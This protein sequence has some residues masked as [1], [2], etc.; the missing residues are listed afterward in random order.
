MIYHIA[1]N[2][3][4]IKFGSQEYWAGIDDWRFGK[5]T[6]KLKFHVRI[7]KYR[8]SREKPPI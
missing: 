3:G 4:G 2:I 1:R 6:S 5:K 7:F 8:R